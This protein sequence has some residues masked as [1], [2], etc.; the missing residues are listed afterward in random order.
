MEKK[1]FQ[2]ESRRLLDLMINSIYTHKEI[3]LRE[4]IS[5][6]S[7]AIDK[8]YYKALTD[9]TIQ[10][11]KD[12]YYIRISTDKDKRTL[13]VTDMGIGMTKEELEDNLGIIAK[14][15]SLNFK[16][17]VESKDGYD[18]IGQFG[19]GFYSAFMVSDKVVVTS[20]AFGE[21]TAYKWVSEGA[22]GYTIEETEKKEP[23]TEIIL[24]L[25]ESNEDED[26]DQYLEEYT[27]KRI[28][29]RYSDFIRYPIK[30]MV[31]EHRKKEDSDEYETV[32]EEKTIN[33]MVPIWR[34]NKNELKDED[35]ENFYSEKHFG[36][37]KPLKWSHM[38]I[39]G[40][41]RYD[42][43]IYIPS[44]APF[45]YYTK[46]YEKGLELYSSGVLIMNKCPELLP[47]YF[48]FVKGI[49]D[50]EDLSLN[51]S[52][53]MLQHDR[54]LR[55]MAKKI[56]EKIKDELMD[57]LENNREKYEEFFGNFGKQLK[58]GLYSDYG[59]NKDKLKELLLFHSS[60]EKKLVTLKE[61][62]ERMPE[63]Q[64]YIYYATGDS[65]DRVDRMPQTEL[66]KDKGY[67]ILYLT[68]EVDEFA[69]KVLQE[70]E[71]KEF[72]SVS[73]DDLGIEED[74]VEEED[75][76]EG[77]EI[78][79]E[80]KN[81]LGDKVKEVRFSKRL[82]NHPVC[83]ATEGE[84]SIE[85][86]KVLNTMPNSGDVHAEKILEINPHHEIFGKLK[87]ALKNDKEK[88]GLYTELLYDQA[89]LIEGLPIEDPVDFA[90]KI[91]KLM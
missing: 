42:A 65:V 10:F 47:D 74:A 77:K 88:F 28:V 49:V 8:I 19:V 69:I 66:V 21:D 31:S 62:V 80:M 53:E 45:D 72:R 85:M 40:M 6:A 33:S 67:E 1:E 30:M 2:A 15:G 60:K 57:L 70:Y 76:E 48:S 44:T 3:F 89:R 14:S 17:A 36:F 43:I 26:Y 68:D 34:K 55:L 12:D 39:D 23:G 11:N 22:E 90:N 35:Y 87:A 51:I 61:Y 18:I 79:Q 13:T 50:S 38:R 71:E 4:L 64:K 9:D 27:I 32:M 73:G 20:R 37:D 84:I 29:K 63:D 5:N 83:F 54:Q 78:F 7:D 16:K 86:E 81:A 52:R 91:A 56:E 41:L 24:T 82:K 59:M 46:E 25:K 58:Y 75:K